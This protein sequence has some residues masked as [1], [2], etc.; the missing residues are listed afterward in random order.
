MEGL[1]DVP[2]W[3]IAF[4]ISGAFHEF[5]H[6][7]SAFRLGDETAAHAGRLTI[8]PLPHIDPVGLIFLILIAISG[9][10]IGWMKP[11]PVNPYNLRNPRRDMMLIALSGPVS[12]IILAAF[13][14]LIFKL[15]PS[16]YAEA[17]PIGR[18][19]VIFLRLN[20]LLAAFNLIPIY[21]L[22]GSKVVEGLLPESL[23]ETW[24]Q[25]YRYGFIILV[26]LFVTGLLWIPLRFIMDLISILIGL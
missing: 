2:L 9:I 3:I 18:L 23:A 17:N 5:A 22:D 20:M 8:N 4:L 19:L 10:G 16:L 21:P 1:R 13:F 25:S 7:W 26:V 11:V 15:A 24:S 6:A 12:N 14:V